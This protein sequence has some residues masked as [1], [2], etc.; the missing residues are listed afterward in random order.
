M[1]ISNEDTVL[2]IA[3]ALDDEALV[4]TRQSTRYA[5]RKVDLIEATAKNGVMAYKV[6]AYEASPQQL[7]QLIVCATR[8]LMDNG[9]CCPNAAPHQTIL[10][11]AQ[12][13]E[14]LPW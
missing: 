3:Q 4:S 6:L 5:Y 14:T 9:S 1:E 8:A 7:A 11:V 10:E 13:N 12:F 2:G